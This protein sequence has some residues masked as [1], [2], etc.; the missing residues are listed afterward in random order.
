LFDYRKYDDDDAGSILEL[1]VMLM[2]L[3]YFR[4]IIVHYYVQLSMLNSNHACQ[5]F[6]ADL[7]SA[8]SSSKLL[9]MYVYMYLWSHIIHSSALETGNMLYICLCGQVLLPVEGPLIQKS[10]TSEAPTDILLPVEEKYS[11][12]RLT[13]NRFLYQWAVHW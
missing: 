2:C 6:V 4:F 5:I 10:I 3:C 9:Y 11:S 8:C 13:G 7:C 12:G 1:S